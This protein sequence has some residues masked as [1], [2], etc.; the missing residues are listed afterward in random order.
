MLEYI[1]NK[2]CAYSLRREISELYASIAIK[3]FAVSMIAIF[4]PIFLFNIFHSIKWVILFYLLVYLCY[5]FLIPLGGHLVSRHGFEHSILLSIPLII[6][7]FF[8]LYQ[9]KNYYFL[10]FIAP[11]ILA[12]YKSIYWPAQ[13][14]D[15]AHYG[16]S[17]QRGTEVSICFSLYNIISIIGPLVGGFIISIFGF[18]VLFLLSS[19]IMFTSAIPLFS[20]KEFFIPNDFSY[21]AAMRRFFK[22]HANYTRKVELAF[23]GFGAELIRIIIWPIFIYLVIGD[24][25]VIGILITLSLS[26]ASICSLI[27]GK[28]IDR[29]KGGMIIKASVIFSFFTWIFRY[30][31]ASLT[32]IFIIDFLDRNIEQGISLPVRAFAFEEGKKRGF[33]KYIVFSEMSL[34]IGKILISII[35]LIILSFTDSCFLIFFIAGVFSLFYLFL[36]EYSS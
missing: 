18:K 16:N 12:I 4:E 19:F 29:K 13:H 14:T 1:K 36:P 27:I 7:Y 10:F 34:A 35:S 26:I 31:L 9:I 11:F 8:L 21:V 15:M 22:P 17:Y 2:I 20:T 23:L 3:S 6:F 32:G 33:L 30:F 28:A 24:Y 25:K 5:F